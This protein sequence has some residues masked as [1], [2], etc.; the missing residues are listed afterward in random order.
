MQQLNRFT[1]RKT[2]L[3]FSKRVC[4]T[5]TCF[6]LSG[7][8]RPTPVSTGY[9][10]DVLL[11]PD[12][13]TVTGLKMCP[14]GK[15]AFSHSKTPRGGGHTMSHREWKKNLK[16]NVFVYF[17]FVFWGKFRSAFKTSAES[18]TDEAL[19]I[20]DARVHRETICLKEVRR[21]VRLAADALRSSSLCAT[22]VC[23]QL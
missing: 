10:C 11:H 14:E 5:S 15:N 17:V 21:S 12:Y 8:T 13:R 1:P 19:S 7:D 6:T 22:S 3:C 23:S 18:G 16:K 4:C 20:C 9:V 2:C